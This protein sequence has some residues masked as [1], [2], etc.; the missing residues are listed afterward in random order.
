MTVTYDADPLYGTVSASREI[1]VY[2]GDE[3]L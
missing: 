2:R 1:V 3:R